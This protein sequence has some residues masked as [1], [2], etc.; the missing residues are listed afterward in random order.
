MSEKGSLKDWLVS[1]YLEH[2][3]EK[4]GSIDALLAKYAT[5]E[6]DLVRKLERKYEG[7]RDGRRSSD[8]RSNPGSDG[9][10]SNPFEDD[11]DDDEFGIADRETALNDLDRANRKLALTRDALRACFEEN[12]R[13][14]RA[15]VA[16]SELACGLAD[17]R[18]RL[19]DVGTAAL[20]RQEELERANRE[21]DALSDEAVRLRDENAELR[22]ALAATRESRRE[23]AANYC[24][25]VDAERLASA[26]ES[27]LAALFDACAAALPAVALERKKRLDAARATTLC[28]ECGE[29][30]RAKMATVCA[31][32]VYCHGC[33]PSGASMC[34]LCDSVILA[35]QWTHVRQV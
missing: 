33:Q 3:P 28:L 11:D 5:R 26:A 29:R 20:E 23:R 31:H 4:L 12:G 35:N 13:L 10:G 15:I 17:A 19:D 9:G 6:N 7:R 34:P 1:F 30:P 2:N 22:E 32:L 24:A 27:D 18:A 14:Q 16:S 8:Q 25:P 21:R